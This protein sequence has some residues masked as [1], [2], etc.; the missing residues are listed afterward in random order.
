MFLKYFVESGAMSVRRVLKRDLTHMAK[1]SRASILSLLA[2]LEDEE[3]FETTML[4]QV[5]EVVQ[6]RICDD[7]LILIKK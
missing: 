4:G 2:N 3:T 5:K 7:E 1:A 6:E